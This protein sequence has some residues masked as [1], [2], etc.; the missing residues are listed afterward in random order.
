M[1]S[2]I[3]N[4]DS[5]IERCFGKGE[6]NAQYRLGK[7][8]ELIFIIADNIPPEFKVMKA[9]IRKRASENLDKIH[10][11]KSIN[12][13]MTQMTTEFETKNILRD[14]TRGMI[15]AS[16]KRNV[17][18]N[19]ATVK[20]GKVMPEGWTEK[21]VNLKKDNDFKAKLR[22]IVEA[23]AKDPQN[24]DKEI[25]AD[26]DIIDLGKK[27]KKPYMQKLWWYKL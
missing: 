20:E 18:A 9:H 2:I 13:F 4:V 7:K 10:A 17:G 16:K 24:K 25:W 26:Q 23:K 14:Y 6:S 15:P 19:N 22:A 27:E 1:E 8:Y 5:H 11:A 21:R 3:S 12:D